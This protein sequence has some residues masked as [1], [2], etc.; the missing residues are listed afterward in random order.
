MP[1]ALLSLYA[2]T[3]SEFPRIGISGS[4]VS[5]N[6]PLLG[7]SVNKGTAPPSFSSL[8]ADFLST[9]DIFVICGH[10]QR[11]DNPPGKREKRGR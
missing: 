7:S 4:L 5:E 11:A 2:L 1:P 8:G 9:L 6:T 3:R 10:C